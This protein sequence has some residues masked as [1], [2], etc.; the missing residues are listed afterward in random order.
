MNSQ[1]QEELASFT[2][3]R[4]YYE[5]LHLLQEIKSIT[6]LHKYDKNS[7]VLKKTS[8]IKHP[9]YDTYIHHVKT[10]SKGGEKSK[11]AKSTKVLY[12][13]NTEQCV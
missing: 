8:S 3:S 12:T 5:I 13:V 4:K 7:R 1:V 2:R 10:V 9:I 11:D 6:G